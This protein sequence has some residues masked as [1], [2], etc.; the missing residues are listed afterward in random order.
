MSFFLYCYLLQL[1]LSYIIGSPIRT[2]VAAAAA[3]QGSVQFGLYEQ[4]V[5][6]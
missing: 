3:A 4:S 2:T 5:N 1:L 6:C